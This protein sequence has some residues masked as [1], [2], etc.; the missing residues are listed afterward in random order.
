VI[1]RRR[2]KSVV[3]VGSNQ[4]GESLVAVPVMTLPATYTTQA[5]H[6]MRHTKFSI[7]LVR[8]QDTEY[9]KL[10]K[11]IIS[12][13]FAFCDCIPIIPVLRIFCTSRLYKK[14]YPF[15]RNVYPRITSNFPSTTW[16]STKVPHSQCLST[17]ITQSKTSTLAISKR[18]IPAWPNYYY[19]GVCSA[20]C[21]FLDFCYISI[22]FGFGG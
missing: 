22:F 1:E 20:D 11:S 5:S 19:S 16:T 8:Y 12:S 10:Y 17:I 7:C 18:G 2:N 21:A 6:F 4:T 13:E 3:R 14:I 15:L 9:I